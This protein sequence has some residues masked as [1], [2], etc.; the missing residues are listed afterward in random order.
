MNQLYT[1]HLLGKNWLKNR[2]VMSPMTR[3]RAI[4]NIPNDLMAEYYA[5]RAGAGLIVTEGTSPS[6]NGLGYARIPGVFSQEQVQGWKKVTDAV[7]KNDGRIFVQIMHTGRVGT[8][9]NLPK[10][11]EVLAPS[12]I[13]MKGTIWTDAEGSQPH[14]T[15]KEMSKEDIK[16]TVQEY[17]NAAKLAT[18]AGFDG[19]ELHGAN[20]YLIDQFIN[21]T[22]NQRTDEYGGS[23]SNRNRFALEVAKAVVEAIGPDKVAIRISP[24]GVFNDLGIFDEIK[25]QY[26]E[27]AS[28]LG[29]L[30]LVYIHIVDH[31]SM[32]A[33]KPEASTIESIR[34]AYKA[35]NANGTFILS[36]GYDPERA[37]KDLS[38]GDADLIAFGKSFISNPDLVTRLEKGLAL[39][40][41]DASTFYTPG[42]KGYTD[43][44]VA[45]LSGV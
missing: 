35:G 12:A 34:K 39:A 42:E 8:T 37:H 27:L 7:H 5:Q 36:G 40:E 22:S 11:A 2:V 29:K 17:A 43:Y 25:E 24:Y 38:S 33:P 1:K 45:S 23:P 18:E 14:T 41:P 20:G 30:G 21:P 9:I 32:G 6:P 44:P 19:V 13:E 26:T 15:P 31:S 3:S 10:G 16:K 28:S 4:G